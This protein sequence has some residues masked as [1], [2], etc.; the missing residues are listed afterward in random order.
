LKN[1]VELVTKEDSLIFP[2]HVSNYLWTMNRT[3]VALY[4]ESGVKVFSKDPKDVHILSDPIV[5]MDLSMS[6]GVFGVE[7][8]RVQP[9][10]FANS[11]K[12]SSNYFHDTFSKGG[13]KSNYQ[14]P[15]FGN[16]SQPFGSSSFG[17]AQPFGQVNPSPF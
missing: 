15:P 10:E 6:Q 9:P 1:N 14:P 13:F 7:A 16:N 12:H 3:H 11:W 4:C 8:T 17:Q 5:P 2:N